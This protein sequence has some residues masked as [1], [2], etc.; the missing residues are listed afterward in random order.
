MD[1]RDRLGFGRDEHVAA[2][3]R[4]AES[5]Q[6]HGDRV[7]AVKFVQQPS[8]ELLVA[9][10]LLDLRDAVVRAKKGSAHCRVLPQ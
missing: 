9:E 6:P 3:S 8:V 4:L 1:E 7:Q 10:G 2:P 5:E